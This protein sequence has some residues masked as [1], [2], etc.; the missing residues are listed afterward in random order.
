MAQAIKIPIKIY[1]EKTVF[2]MIR[3]TKQPFHAWHGM[4]FVIFYRINW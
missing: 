1:L 2:V 3:G 4:T